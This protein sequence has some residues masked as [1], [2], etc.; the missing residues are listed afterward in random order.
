MLMHVCIFWSG[1]QTGTMLIIK[2]PLCQI[3]QC[4]W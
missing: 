3:W 4:N 1:T 2:W